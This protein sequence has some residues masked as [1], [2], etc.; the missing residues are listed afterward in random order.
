MNVLFHMARPLGGDGLS[1]IGRQTASQLWQ[2]GLLRQVTATACRQNG[3]PASHVRT[4]RQQA[5]VDRLLS[6]RGVRRVSRNLDLGFYA[7]FTCFDWFAS[8]N[9]PP[10]DIFHGYPDESLR[11]ARKARQ[12]GAR[13]VM[14]NPTSHPDCE[15][16]LLAAE[17][18]RYGVPWRAFNP[19]RY[20]R[21]RQ[22]LDEAD[23]VLVLSQFARQSFLERGFPDDKLSVV[24][25]GVDSDLFRPRPKHDDV[26]RVLHVGQIGLI[27]GVQYLLEA[28]SRLSLPNAELVLV[29]WTNDNA[30]DLLRRYEGRCTFRVVEHLESMRQVA[31][32]YNQASVFVAASITDGWAMTVTEAMASGL[33]VIVSENVGAKDAVRDGESGF[34][35]PSRSAEAIADRIAEFHRKRGEIHEIGA[36]AREDAVPHSWEQYGERL[37]RAYG[38]LV[39]TGPTTRSTSRVH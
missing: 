27:K 14:D 32:Q 34:I 12:Q 10:C 25:Y 37:V 36:V 28:W 5:W 6:L 13:V 7:N 1:Y 39:D 11:C 24:P 2:R 16:E 31:E 4:V 15:A 3:I 30:V 20:D 9:I 23:Y 29:G 38:R 18:E 33:P 22:A 17:Y 21:W 26:F 8:R 19:R 35:V